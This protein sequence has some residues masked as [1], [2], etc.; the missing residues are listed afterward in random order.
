MSASSAPADPLDVLAR[1]VRDAERHQQH[2]R[3]RV[4]VLL[5]ATFRAQQQARRKRDRQQVS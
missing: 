5:V 3:P 4:V 1:T 2:R